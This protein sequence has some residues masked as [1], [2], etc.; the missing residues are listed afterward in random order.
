ME[1]WANALAKYKPF[2]LH[3]SIGPIKKRVGI[4][5]NG[6]AIIIIMAGMAVV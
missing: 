3:S 1:E 2:W 6:I 4:V 5:Q